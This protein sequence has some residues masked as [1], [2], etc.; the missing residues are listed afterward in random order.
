MPFE[1]V[2][3]N[4]DCDASHSVADADRGR[5]IR[6][7]KCGRSF[8]AAIQTQPLRRAAG[9]K[10]DPAL[11]GR[12]PAMPL[13]LGD[14]AAF[15]RYRIVRQ[16]GL[17][18]MGTVYL[19]H[20]TELDRRVAL[21]VPH[22]TPGDTDFLRR[23]HREAR[24]AAQLS[25]PNICQVFD[26][27]QVDNIPY[28]TMAYIE[29]RPLSKVLAEREGPM[30]E[31]EAVR[32]VRTLALALAEAHARGVV[33]RDLKPAN[34]MIGRDGALVLMDFGLARRDSDERLT[35]SGEMLGT[36]AYMP[37]EQVKGEVQS[38]GPHSD[39]YSLGVILYKL[40]TDHPPFEGPAMRILSLILTQ[41]PP[42]PSAYRRDLDPRLEAICLKAMAREPALR[43]ASM[44]ELVAALDA[45]PDR[46]LPTPPIAAPPALR[47]R[48]WSFAGA[49]VALPVLA[50]TVVALSIL[51][52]ARHEP[53]AQGTLPV[54]VAVPQLPI[55][56][57]PPGGTPPP[58]ALTSPRELKSEATGMVLIRIEP[59]QFLMGSLDSDEEA[60]DDEKPRHRV[61][62]TRPFYLGTHEV[63]QGEYE[64]VMGRNPSWFSARGGGMAR[65]TRRDTR[66]FPVE[67]VSWDDA[68]EFCDR[69]SEREGLTP[70]DRPGA[71][72]PSD[73]DGY[74][75]PTEAE[76]EYA[77]RAGTATKYSSGDD[78]ARLDEF[79]W[80]AGNSSSTAQ[81]V[82]CKDPNAF[83]LHD[84]H[85][86]VW[87]WCADWYEVGYHR[88]SLLVD[89]ISS[90]RTSNRVARG[91]SWYS[92]PSYCRSAN[93]DRFA[94]GDRNDHLGFRVARSQPR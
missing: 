4:P 76:W 27:G 94:P 30:D 83:G 74:R 8:E 43:F 35:A 78:V 23:F 38:I 9:T 69:L 50:L 2:C 48:S 88:D 58:S 10:P 56:H 47:R 82:G 37:P 26:V 34:V 59:G 89:P 52:G 80:H 55:G 21:K 6:C 90:S 61:R 20:D 66:E 12:P 42:P 62:I 31:R 73:G 91:G 85:G 41:D 64:G 5:Q 77:C 36:P 17:G 1:V 14:G 86:N 15:G 44:T 93:R 33:H 87:E 11:D 75:L 7:R 24:A 72:E 57:R 40:L 18:G 68:I 54:P 25:H 45:R 28:L 22:H 71:G 16:L 84:M 32:I 51:R 46:D 92:I 70:Y 60:D 79:A 53:K 39:I 67:N 49:V 13:D 3:P 65:D 29:G 19:A 63:T 81:P